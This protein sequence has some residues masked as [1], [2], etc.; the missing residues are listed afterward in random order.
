MLANGKFRL[1]MFHPSMRNFMRNYFQAAE[2]STE[3]RQAFVKRAVLYT[4]VRLIQSAFERS[5]TQHS[6]PVIGVLLL[7]VSTNV[8]TDAE[9]AQLQLFGLYS[10]EP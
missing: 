3:I 8:L 2:I 4:G 7:Q 6:L 1:P 9:G 10:E 5:S